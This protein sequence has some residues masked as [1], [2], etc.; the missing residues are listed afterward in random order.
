MIASAIAKRQPDT[1][2]SGDFNLPA[3]IDAERTLLGAVL[4][5]DAALHYLVGV[6]NSDDFALDSHRRIYQAMTEMR[7]RGEAVDIV[8]LS[9]VLTGKKEIEAIGGVAYLASL[10]EGLPRHPSC[11]DYVRIVKAKSLLRRLLLECSMA[12][13]KIYAGDSGFAIIDALKAK[14]AEI[15]ASAKNGIRKP[16]G[17]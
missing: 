3:N 16:E 8:T 11:R 15:E 17:T 7:G 1:L 9:D 13:A 6:L 4:L 2:L 10:T 14:I 12:I 5:D